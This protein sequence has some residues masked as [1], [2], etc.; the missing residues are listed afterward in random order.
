V[1]A[2]ALLAGA[3]AVVARAGFHAARVRPGP[4]FQGQPTGRPLPWRTTAGSR[5]ALD[6]NRRIT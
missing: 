5:M 6:G 2:E 1:H 4:G 3:A